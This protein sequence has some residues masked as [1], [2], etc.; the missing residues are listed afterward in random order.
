MQ[1]WLGAYSGEREKADLIARSAFS[2]AL[3]KR[4]SDCA[5]QDF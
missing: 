5:R 3:G 1:S 2:V 4:T